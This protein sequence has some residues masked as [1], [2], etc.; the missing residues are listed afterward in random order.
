[1]P[2]Q[3]ATRTLREGGESWLT[4]VTRPAARAPTR[5]P[6]EREIRAP[7]GR[8]VRPWRPPLALE[9][10][11][12]R[13]SKDTRG[14]ASREA[15]IS[16][17]RRRSRGE[18]RGERP[19]SPPPSELQGTSYR[20]AASFN[21]HLSDVQPKAAPSLWPTARGSGG[22]RAPRLPDKAPARAPA[23]AAKAASL[24]RRP[25]RR[26]SPHHRTVGGSCAT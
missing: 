10:G 21:S 23:A 17:T 5:P 3:V 2:G 12:A 16:C 14:A 20:A 13:Q 25:R 26:T 7:S 24:G 6:M 18:N 1:M 4:A 19:G 9:R 8:G 11:R 15:E 22:S